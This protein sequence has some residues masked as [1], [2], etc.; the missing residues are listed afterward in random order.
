M[1]KFWATTLVCCASVAQLTG[2]AAPTAAYC[3]L[4]EECE[5]FAEGLLAVQDGE[6]WGYVNAKDEVVIDFEFDGASAF[7]N[8]SAI[9]Q[10]DTQ[11]NLIDKSGDLLL[12][13]EVDSIRRV[14]DQKM[15][16]YRVEDEYGFMSE[17]GNVI[18][19]PEFDAYS[20]LFSEGLLAVQ[21][22]TKWGYVNN[23]GATK[24]EAEY[25]SA[26]E[27]SQGLAVV[28]DGLLYGY[29]TP[30]NAVEIDFD[31]TYASSFDAY[32]RAIVT[33]QD[34]EYHLIDKE[35]ED[36]VSGEYIKGT[37][38]IYGVEDEL[39]M[40]R[41]VDAEGDD[42]IGEEYTALWAL[43]KDYANVEFEGEDV[44]QLYD[45]DG[46]VI[47]QELYDES[48]I[49]ED[50]FGVSILVTVDIEA[51]EIKIYGYEKVLTFEGT[52][53]NQI[54]KE[55]VII[56]RNEKYG[57]INYEGDTEVEFYYDEMLL[58]NNQYYLVE[59]NGKYGVINKSGD[60]IVSFDYD[61]VNP[62]DNVYS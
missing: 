34:G 33:T 52:E 9:V 14:L 55:I 56:Q 41:I 26:R 2:C 29:I 58:F 45:T 38:P 40:H 24:I 53:L 47:R 1:R 57:A 62:M 36:I 10:I 3:E 5:L 31:Y 19:A 46:S 30:R 49:Y 32:D 18:K 59:V 42:F 12:D 13:D 48:D 20:G 22:G 35:G 50:D 39:G 60:T 51:E 37:G 21:M 25:D 11:Y 54:N 43:G 17:S 8:G 4:I 6:L 61:F 7:I 44:Y 15:L 23:K 27:F 16:I 28:K